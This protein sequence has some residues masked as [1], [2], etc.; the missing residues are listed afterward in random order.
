[1]SSLTFGAVFAALVACGFAPIKAGLAASI[2]MTTSPAVILFMAHETRAEGQVTER[3][4]NLVALNGLLA[5]IVVTIML[6][7]A[8]FARSLDLETAV[9]LP[10]YL[11]VGSLML[12]AAMAAFARVVARAVE[13]SSDMH[14]TLILG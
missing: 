2:A 13:R 9:F 14:F 3:A 1:A 4:I 10:L 7:S 8:H 6:G 5:S 11:L 12:G